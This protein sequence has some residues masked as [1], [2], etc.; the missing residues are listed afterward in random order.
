[1]TKPKVKYPAGLYVANIPGD[2]HVIKICEEGAFY[3]C[4]YLDG[5]L[6]WFRMSILGLKR[7]FK[8]V[9]ELIP[10]HKLPLIPRN[11]Q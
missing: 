8:D 2:L 5:E 9:G 6:F 4:Q 7:L 3:L 1:M 10:M 11:K